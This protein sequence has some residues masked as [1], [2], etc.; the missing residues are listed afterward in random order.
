MGRAFLATGERSLQDNRMNQLGRARAGKARCPKFE[1]LGTSNPELQMS[2]PNFGLRLS[3]T[4]R[5]SRVTDHGADG[6]VKHLLAD[7]LFFLC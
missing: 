1:V 2:T 7:P 3:R 5:V 6:L 4:F